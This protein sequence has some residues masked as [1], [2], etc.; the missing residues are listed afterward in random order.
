MAVYGGLHEMAHSVTAYL[1]AQGGSLVSSNYGQPPENPVNSTEAVR[2]TLLWVTPQPTHRND[3]PFRTLGGL[4]EPTPLTLSAYLMFTTYGGEVDPAGAY[5]LLGRILR[6]F[7]ETPVL[8]LP[9]DGVGQGEL[10]LSLVPTA[11]DLMEKIFSPLQ[12]KHRPFVLYE[13][14]PIQLRPELNPTTGA[15][16]VKPGG[17]G[18][19]VRTRV[20]PSIVRVTP[21][22]Q[23]RGGAVRI[24]LELGGSALGVLAIGGTAVVATPI[25]GSRALRAIVPALLAES[26]APLVV[27]TDPPPGL[28]SEPVPLALLPTGAASIDALSSDASPLAAPLL[29]SGTGLAGATLALLWPDEA[30]PGAADVRELPLAA[31]SPTSVTIGAAALA[32][33]LS[34]TPT[35]RSLVDVPLRLVLRLASGEPTPYVLARFV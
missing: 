16:P 29:L 27:R 13:A 8:S 23:I 2:V 9:I 20:R 21:E 1:R 33:A 22:R 10:T 26:S 12:L 14:A 35:R 4:V 18:L 31:V 3:A 30:A 11:A 6:L 15:P 5:E 24:D 19:D 17:V 25:A 32:A 7:H 28:W 34:A